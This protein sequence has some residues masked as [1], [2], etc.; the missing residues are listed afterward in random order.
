MLYLPLAVLI[1]IVIIL[2]SPEIFSAHIPV[3]SEINFEQKTTLTLTFSIAIFAAIEGYSTYVR[4]QLERTKFK[5]ENAKEEL[6]KAYGPLYSMLNKAA[7]DTD[8]TA[9]WLDFEERKRLDEIMATFPFMFPP[10]INEFWRNKI[11]MLGSNLEAENLNLK[12]IDINFG[13]YL[14]FKKMINEEYTRKVQDF[15]SLMQA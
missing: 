10:Q 12:E 5:L 8:K 9:F 4:A 2:Y 13:V 14:E 7:K 1:I 11:Q 6:E 3:F 15:H